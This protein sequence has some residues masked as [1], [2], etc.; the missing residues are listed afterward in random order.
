[1]GYP[2]GVKGYKV[3]LL[4]EKKCHISRNV[5]FQ[6]NDVCKDVT[7]KGKQKEDDQHE[8]TEMAFDIDLGEEGDITSGGDTQ[9]NNEVSGVDQHEVENQET[10]DQNDKDDHDSENDQ[11]QEDETSESPDSYHL[12]RDRERRTVRATRRFDIEGYFSE[13]TDDEEDCF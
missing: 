8:T 1:M 2:S 4:E 6:E 11:D 9:S 13:D 10:S 12:V 3:W 7:R 5:I